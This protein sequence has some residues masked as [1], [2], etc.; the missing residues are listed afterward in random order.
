MWPNT[1]TLV[2]FIFDSNVISKKRKS[3][4]SIV[5]PPLFRYENQ[6]E[7]CQTES[8]P[9]LNFSH[10]RTDQ[11]SRSDMNHDKYGDKVFN[12]R[13]SNDM[14]NEHKMNVSDEITA[15]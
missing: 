13:K 12:K 4:S 8:P 1:K 7:R 10:T 9:K 5:L 2:H 11:I 3:Y 15:I 6:E 14:A